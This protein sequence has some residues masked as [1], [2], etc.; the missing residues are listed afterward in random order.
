MRKLLFILVLCCLSLSA[1]TITISPTV[2]NAN[3]INAGV[4]IGNC[5]YYQDIFCKNHL[6]GL[7]TTF[8]PT[9]GAQ[10]F[11]VGAIVL[12]DTTHIQANLN[13]LQ[14]DSVANNFYPTYGG[15]LVFQSGTGANVGATKTI[16]S[17]TQANAAVA[18]T[19]TTLT[20]SGTLTATVSVTSGSL[21]SVGRTF[22]I[23]IA[24]VT[25]GTGTING[26]F[27]ATATTSTAFTYVSAGSN[28]SG[29][30][31]GTI[32]SGQG[33]M[34]TL[35]SALPATPV[36]GDIFQ[37][38]WTFNDLPT[39][40]SASGGAVVS[41]ET[42][43]VC[44]AA[45]TTDPITS[46]S[47]GQGCGSQSLKCDSSAGGSC[48]ISY[49]V[50]NTS[51]GN[52]LYLNNSPILT[53][54]MTKTVSGTPTVSISVARTGSGAWSYSLHPTLAGVWT[55][56]TDTRNLTDA[57]TSAA[58]GEVA[59]TVTLSGT[60][61]Q[62][63]DNMFWGDA[64]GDPANTTLFTDAF[65]H[66]IKAKKVGVLRHWRGG[67]HN[68]QTAANY[69]LPVQAQSLAGAGLG[70]AYGGGDIGFSLHD[71]LT[72]CQKVGAVPHFL[73]PANMTFADAPNLIDYL[74]GGS[75]TT[76]GAKRIA[77][78]GPSAAGGWASVFPT[79]LA[80]YMNETWNTG[81][82]GQ[83]LGFRSGEPYNSSDYAAYAKTMFAAMRGT[84]SYNSALVLMAD[85]QTGNPADTSS[86][87]H[88][89]TA[90]GGEIN[91][92]YAFSLTTITPPA[93]LYGPT[94]M[95]N[96][97]NTHATNSASGFYQ[98]IH[99]A[100]SNCGAS[101]TAACKFFVY[102][103][104]ISAEQTA[105]TQACSDSVN[106][107]GVG[108]S[109]EFENVLENID[110]GLVSTQALFTE[111]QYFEGENGANRHLWGINTMVG[112]QLTAFQAA[113]TGNTDVVERPTGMGM[114][115]ANACNLGTEITT[116]TSGVTALALASATNGVNAISGVPS[117]RAYAFNSG[118][119]YCLGLVNIDPTNSYTVG[120]TSTAVDP[121]TSVTLT[122]INPPTLA[123]TNEAASNSST[124]GVAATVFPTVTAGFNPH[125]SGLTMAPGEVATLSFSLGSSSGGGTI[126]GGV[127]ASGGVSIH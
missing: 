21:P 51:Q 101:N 86:I 6:F 2:K 9:I 74:F 7:N 28:A 115:L 15:T 61:V 12:T 1:Q 69:I 67:G 123:S 62:Y 102:E 122:T 3:T 127:K 92:Y 50:D 37:M 25:G 45:Q 64:P 99:S 26:T 5:N 60:G 125:A 52:F 78:G 106:Q 85:I 112:G 13:N 105:C 98:Q 68:S 96:Y 30:S 72:L 70:P 87:L 71:F 43:D 8:E 126:N 53:S 66:D 81:E 55:Q 83:G 76:F 18:G 110:T 24:G 22:G 46:V 124:N 80:D 107:A 109:T 117:I 119:N 48:S 79:I 65:Y 35:A 93:T 32:A 104:M 40:V 73:I 14:F 108:T 90:D 34:M 49:A 17:N 31:G 89:S 41:L 120:F 19:I 58:L 54:Y 56:Q 63:F 100:L 94:M 103:Q 95:E 114:K 82:I 111:S 38:F 116:S 27:T 33:S 118:T 47:P 88:D 16:S 57:S 42:S 84:A 20:G 36:N 97:A 39:N 11:Q 91:D 121:P 44:T 23:K 4:N 10:I 59:I 113:T 29:T 75:G 77:L